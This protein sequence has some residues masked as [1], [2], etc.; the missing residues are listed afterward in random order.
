MLVPSLEVLLLGFDVVYF[1]LDL[2]LVTD[3]L[4]A[5]SLGTAD[6]RVSF[7]QRT[8]IFPSQWARQINWEGMEPN[9]GAFL[10]KATQGGVL[11]WKTFLQKVVDESLVNDQRA[12]SLAFDSLKVKSYVVTDCYTV[13]LSRSLQ[14]S[15]L[16]CIV[17][18]CSVV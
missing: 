14:S 4:P 6:L 13:T 12:L 1:D 3:P 10:A 5:I 18:Y 15:V 16:Y 8:C 17:V 7:E 9:T 11:L 2:T